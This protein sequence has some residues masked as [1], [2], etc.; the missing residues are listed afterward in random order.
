MN[1]NQFSDV[2]SRL[3]DMLAQYE[4]ADHLPPLMQEAVQESLLQRFEYT[5]ETA[6]KSAKR[7]LVEQ[8]GYSQEMGPKTVLRLCGELGLLDA[9]NWLLYL[10]ARQDIAHDYSSEKAKAVLDLATNFYTDARRFY[11]ALNAKLSHDD[12][13]QP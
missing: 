11:A 12:V 6:W 4:Q 9:E 13:E 5:L 7:Y 8:E 10:Q 1:L 2:L 3:G